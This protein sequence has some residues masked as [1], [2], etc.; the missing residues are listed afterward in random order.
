MPK[1]AGYASKKYKKGMIPGTVRMSPY[2][3]MAYVRSFRK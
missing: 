2:E 1:K 3:K